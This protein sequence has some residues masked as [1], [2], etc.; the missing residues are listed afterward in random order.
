VNLLVAV[1]FSPVTDRVVEVAA[2]LARD[3]GGA[4]TILHVARPEPEFVGY[5]AGPQSVRD[6]VATEFRLQ[7]RMLQDL[8]DRLRAAEVEATPV[9]VQ[10]S[11]AETIVEHA[12]RIGAALIVVG[13]HGR[14]AVM[15]LLVGSVSEG[16]IRRSPIPVL[17]VPPLRS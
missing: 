2:A 7:R 8:A 10:G 6:Q 3:C 14:G 9:M 12:T 15:D 5:E 16:V 17:V 1:D 13:T 11:I 4:I